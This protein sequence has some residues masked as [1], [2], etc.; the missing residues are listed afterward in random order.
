MNWS[1]EQARHKVFYQYLFMGHPK[2]FSFINF[3]DS[4]INVDEMCQKSI[5]LAWSRGSKMWYV[6]NYSI[7]PHKGNFPW[8]TKNH[9]SAWIC[10]KY[11]LSTSLLS[12][13]MIS[14]KNISNW[15]DPEGQMMDMTQN[16]SLWP[17]K[18]NFPGKTENNRNTWICLKYNLS[19]SLL[20]T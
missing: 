13:F 15:P 20:S 3:D 12:A 4:F 18:D 2:Y 16:Y 5:S 10:L 8:K 19:T 6:P 14:V 1:R 11:S 7:S 9:K 17:H